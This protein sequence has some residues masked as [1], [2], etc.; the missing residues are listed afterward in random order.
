MC[1]TLYVFPLKPPIQVKIPCSPEA[2]PGAMRTWLSLSLASTADVTCTAFQGTQPPP[3]PVC[4]YSLA[5]LARLVWF[6]CLPGPPMELLFSGR[7][8]LL[9]DD[10]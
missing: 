7:A 2:L 4:F 10:G 8:R 3:E 9:R 1:V 5:G 6:A